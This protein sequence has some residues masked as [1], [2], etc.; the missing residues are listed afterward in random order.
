MVDSVIVIV[1]MQND[2]CD[3]R[4]FYSARDGGDFRMNVV[5]DKIVEFYADMK[6]AGREVVCFSITYPEGD[7]PCVENSWGCKY[8][9]I[10]PQRHFYKN[11]FSCFSNGDFCAWLEENNVNTI[12]ICGFQMTFCVKATFLEAKKRGYNVFLIEDLIGERKK[13]ADKAADF[14]TN[15]CGSANI[16]NSKYFYEGGR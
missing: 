2:Y 13:H 5:A 12:Y 16:V 14:L 10:M 15:T 9:K 7:N 3:T 6:N 11:E 4:G 1:D 8:Y